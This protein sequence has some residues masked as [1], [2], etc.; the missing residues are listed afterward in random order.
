MLTAREQAASAYAGAFAQ[1]RARVLGARMGEVTEERLVNV[2]RAER[3]ITAAFGTS[4]Y[5][6]REVDD[7]GLSQMLATIAEYAESL[8]RD[9]GRW[10]DT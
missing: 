5:S 10:G 2:R 1:G 7:A 6:A 3:M 4:R 8:T 9:R